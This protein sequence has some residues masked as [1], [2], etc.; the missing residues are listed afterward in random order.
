MATNPY[1][2]LKQP[3]IIQILVGDESFGAIP[4]GYEFDAFFGDVPKWVNIALPYL[5]ISEICDISTRFGFSMQCDE[6]CLIYEESQN[7]HHEYF[8]KM[9]DQFIQANCCPQLLTFLFGKSQFKS[10]LSDL[11]RGKI[12]EYYNHI[13]KTVLGKINSILH[14]SGHEM[15]II[16]QEFVVRPSGT[17]L[18]VHAPTIEKTIDRPYIAD[19]TARAL[20]DIEAGHFDSALTKSK[21]LLEE[22]FKYVIEQ[23]GEAPPKNASI[24]ESYKCVRDLYNMNAEKENDKRINKLISGLTKI[25]SAVSEMRNSNSDAHGLGKVRPYKIKDY[26][27][28]LLVNASITLADF[29]LS[30]AQNNLS[31]K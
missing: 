16:G 30:V 1:E 15:K 21:T 4:C 6:E 5:P 22:V 7:L 8:E 25:I 12:D 13:V 14:F 3:D 18:E 10:K 19:I 9:L 29:I 17:K 11:P 28:R 20:Q 31:Q 23:K 24:D 2:L 26:Y 27:A